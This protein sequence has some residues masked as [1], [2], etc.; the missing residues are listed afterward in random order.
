MFF[1]RMITASMLCSLTLAAQDAFMG[2]WKGTLTTPDGTQKTV[3]AQVVPQGKG[4]YRAVF[5]Q[6]L[7]TAAKDATIATSEGSVKD[8]KLVFKDGATID[9]GT[10]SRKSAQGTMSLTPYQVKS[11][12]LGAQPPKNAHIILD[13]QTR[14][15]GFRNPTRAAAIVDL[16]RT[17]GKTNN[18]VGYMLTEVVAAEE[19]KAILKSGSDDGIVIFLNGAKIFEKD[20]PRMVVRDDDVVPITLKKGS[21]VLLLKI[22]QGGGD[23]KA[24]ARICGTNNRAVPGLTYQLAGTPAPVAAD[25][26]IMSWHVAGPFKRH[27]TDRR[28]LAQISFAPEKGTFKDWKTVS[29]KGESGERWLVRDDGSI[30]IKPRGGGMVSVKEPA[31]FTMHLEFKNAFMPDK[32]GQGR[33][34]SGV[35]IHGRY[36]IQI[37]DSYTL[38]LRNNDCAGIYQQFVPAV[39]ACLPP[40]QWQT[41]DI[42]FTAATFDKDG[43]K[44]ADARLTLRH[45]GILVHDNIPIKVTPGGMGRT[46]VPKGPLFLQDHGNPVQF[47]NIWFVE[48]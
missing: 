37:L 39:N 45:N 1:K 33:S 2:D 4:T 42:D 46:D 10:L 8:G 28:K 14:L 18:C 25:G 31:S 7:Y 44:T 27:H 26:T 16:N 47:R 15:S 20:V 34:N 9:N 30:E 21:N 41:Y 6:E 13:S 48:K 38:Q 19:T 11:P 12:T 40:A 3:F 43:N 24:T 35:Y 32:R 23:W 29:L 22:I 36:E 17:L 5:K